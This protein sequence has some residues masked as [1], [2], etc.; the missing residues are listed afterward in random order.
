MAQP[1]D[2]AIEPLTPDLWPAFEDLFGKEGACFGC[3]CTYFRMGPA[4][5]K[6][7]G[8]VGKRAFIHARIEAGPPPGLLAFSGGRAVG[9]MQIGPR[10]DV[11]EWNG[12]RRAS[13]PLDEGDAAD[14]GVWAVSCFF[15]RKSARGTGLSHRLLA[16]GIDFARR[17]GAR[18]VEA[19]PIRNS[20]DTSRM[21]LFVGSERVFERAGFSIVAERRAGRPLMRLVL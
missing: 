5:R 6:A 14:A 9:W 19:C 17:N 20:Q 10:G 2:D 21:G 4:E 13:A 8:H 12:G 3:W 18:I 16:A 11:P 1:G 15:N 7:T